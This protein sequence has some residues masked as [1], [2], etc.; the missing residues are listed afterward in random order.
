MERISIPLPRLKAVLSPKYLIPVFFILAFAIWF[1]LIRP[2]LWVDAARVGAYSSVIGADI[3][4]RLAEMGPQ[5]GEFVKKGELLFKLDRDLALAKMGAEKVHVQSLEKQ[6]RWEKERLDKIM[7]DYINACAELEVGAC[8]S[9]KVQSQ[10]VVMQES[11]TKFEAVYSQLEKVRTDLSLLDLE[12]QKMTLSAPFDGV[13]LKRAQNPGAVVSFGAPVYVL[14]DLGRLWIDAE[15]PEN[16]LSQIKVGTEARIRFHAYP[17]QERKGQVTWIGPSVEKGAK[18][19]VKISLE[20][21]DPSLIPGLSAE[22]GL[23]VR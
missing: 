14:A 10:L 21:T 2:Y 11:Q 9:E 1:S 23:K 19:P 12:V 17:G 16:K 22:V 6:M 13:V 18:I 15:I 20:A 5:E 3:A 8:T 7:E 4:G